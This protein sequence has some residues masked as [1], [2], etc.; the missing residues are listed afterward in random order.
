MRHIWFATRAVTLLG[1]VVVVCAPLGAGHAQ[2]RAATQTAGVPPEM[3]EFLDAWLVY[4]NMTEAMAYFDGSNL[5]LSLAPRNV[6][7]APTVKEYF[8]NGRKPEVQRLS[9]TERTAYWTVLNQLWP[10]PDTR[11]LDGLGLPHVLNPV[12]PELIAGFAEELGTRILSTERDP[13]IVFEAD[14]EVV[15]YSFDPGFGDIGLLLEDD[16]RTLGLLAELA[17]RAHPEAGPF[18]SFWGEKATG[19]WRIQ[20]L[21]AIRP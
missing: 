10:R 5:S 8:F 2:E 13:F 16:T 18:V 15:L 4:G 6:Q 3:R 7:N 14:S 19:V 1:L 20:A 21:G 17:H 12:H 11:Q 9:T